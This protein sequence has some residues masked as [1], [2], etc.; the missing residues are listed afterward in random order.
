MHAFRSLPAQ[1]DWEARQATVLSRSGVVMPQV[2][3]EQH[4]PLKLS[5]LTQIRRLSI[6]V[7]LLW[8]CER[9]P[10]LKGEFLPST[11]PRKLG[12]SQVSKV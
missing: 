2:Q 7:Y 1:L 12:V 9:N 6:L 10:L 11:F 3:R 4:Q 8:N 5:P